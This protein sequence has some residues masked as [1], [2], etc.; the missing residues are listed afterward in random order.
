MKNLYSLAGKIQKPVNKRS[1]ESIV[2][3]LHLRNPGEADALAQL[4]KFFMPTKSTA[5]TLT[6]WVASAAAVK[7]VRRYLSYVWSD[8]KTMVA[9][10]GHRLHGAPTDLPSGLYDP[11]S[12]QKVWD[13]DDPSGPGRY[14]D[15]P[16]IVPQRETVALSEVSFLAISKTDTAFQFGTV[17]STFNLQQIQQATERCERVSVINDSDSAYFE[18]P[19]GVFAVVMP[20]RKPRK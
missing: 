8:G 1:A 6:A 5:K 2:L 3:E 7:D 13:L 18:G 14:P 11:V 15:W 19:Q 20:N 16:R 10:D 12:L 4:L 17:L 9:T